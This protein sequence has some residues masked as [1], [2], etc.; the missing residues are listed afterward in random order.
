[1][2]SLF[3]EC[4]PVECMRTFEQLERRTL[5]TVVLEPMSVEPE[6]FERMSAE[7]V[8]LLEHRPE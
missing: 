1:M 4:S 6:Q 3:E 7:S 2:C 8:E 5:A